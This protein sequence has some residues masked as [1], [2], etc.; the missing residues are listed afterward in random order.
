MRRVA[1]PV[2]DE[3]HQEEVVF[4]FFFGNMPSSDSLVMFP[5]SIVLKTPVRN[6]A[7]FNLCR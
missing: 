3:A 5:L 1:V 6:Y 4:F 2:C 7:P